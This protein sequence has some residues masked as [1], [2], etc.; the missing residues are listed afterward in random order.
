MIRSWRALVCAAVLLLPGMSQAASYTYTGIFDPTAAQYK[1]TLCFLKT[2]AD[3]DRWLCEFKS[4]DTHTVTGPL[5]VPGVKNG[6]KI[7][8]VMGCGTTLKFD[9]GAK[10]TIN[11][12][13]LVWQGCEGNPI[14][15]TPSGAANG[16]WDGVRLDFVRTFA[17]AESTDFG[18]GISQ[19]KIVGAKTALQILS[20]EDG[21]TQSPAIVLHGI[22]IDDAVNTGVW[23]S[24]SNVK[25]TSLS[26]DNVSSLGTAKGLDIVNAVVE[27]DGVTMFNVA[28]DTEASFIYATSNSSLIVKS[29]KLQWATA[30][31]SGNA[32][33]VYMYGGDLTI[34]ET[35]IQHVNAVAGKALGV[36]VSQNGPPITITLTN[37]T[38]DD[39]YSTAD[40]SI[41]GVAISGTINK[42]NVSGLTIS[43]VVQKSATV[44]PGSAAFGMQYLGSGPLNINGK[45]TI[46]TVT[47][48]DKGYATG[49]HVSCTTC[50]LLGNTVDAKIV[51]NVTAEL[52][53]ANGIDTG[54]GPAE[55]SLTNL[56]V[57]N[58]V[59]KGSD[60]YGARLDAQLLSLTDSKILNVA[61][62]TAAYGLY[63]SL[64]SEQQALLTR[65]TVDAISTTKDAPLYGI[66]VVT[67]SEVVAPSVKFVDLSV[68][69]IVQDTAGAAPSKVYGVSFGSKQIAYQIEGCLI[70]TISGATAAEAIYA[71]GSGSISKC[72]IADVGSKDQKHAFGINTEGMLTLL[73]SSF[74][75]IIGFGSN[76]AAVYVGNTTTGTVEISDNTFDGITGVAAIFLTGNFSPTIK[77]L[78]NKI[79]RWG[80]YGIFIGDKTDPRPLLRNNLVARPLFGPFVGPRYGIYIWNGDVQFNTVDCGEL[81]NHG[82]FVA[83]TVN[84]D[85]RANIAQHCTTSGIRFAT[86]DPLKHNIAF[87]NGANN[88]CNYMKSAACSAVAPTDNHADDPKLDKNWMPTINSPAYLFTEVDPASFTNPPSV[89]LF[90]TKRLGRLDIGAY[91]IPVLRTLTPEKV[92]RN[93]SGATLTVQGY[94]LLKDKISFV[95]VNDGVKIK[96]TVWDVTVDELTDVKLSVDVDKALAPDTLVSLLHWHQALSET[97]WTWKDA[98][99]IT[100]NK[101]PVFN[102]PPGTAQCVAGW[103]CELELEIDDPDN[104]DL[105]V[106]S[107]SSDFTLSEQNTTNNQTKF[108]LSFRTLGSE[109]KQGTVTITAGDGLNNATHQVALT[110]VANTPP[111]KP[112]LSEPAELNGRRESKDGKLTWLAVAD[113]TLDPKNP[114][115]Y[116]CLVS[117][118]SDFSTGVSEVNAGTALEC[119]PNVFAENQTYFVK[120]RAVDGVEPT[121]YTDS[122]VYAV[123]YNSTN[124]APPAPSAVSP[125]DQSVFGPD[126]AIALTVANVVDPEQDSVTYEFELALANDFAGGNLVKAYTAVAPGTTNTNQLLDV[127]LT[128][129]TTYFWRARAVDAHGLAGPWS[130]V[131]SFS[132]ASPP[133]SDAGDDATPGDDSVTPDAQVDGTTGTDTAPASDIDATTQPGPDSV[134]GGDTTAGAE[135]STSTNKKGGGCT[136]QSSNP[137]GTSSGLALLFVLLLGG[138][139]YRR[140]RD[141]TS[142]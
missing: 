82:I 142:V 108:T 106:T 43:N 119:T 125:V 98:L 60:A 56:T 71:R 86:A 121:K 90:G 116:K 76:S 93:S 79:Q 95:F 15:F 69:N 87:D 113:A 89:S 138:W 21:K 49:L 41:G 48:K 1:D 80:D 126:D 32:F 54:T 128:P 27:V 10:L 42:V 25:F 47:A 62:V 8:L 110:T 37:T 17:L 26:I 7:R 33:G 127:A 118:F 103:I 29:G 114:T 122:D 5:S 67:P 30:I 75:K 35:L 38:I 61:G 91:E 64:L 130:A 137:G 70:Q 14:V 140:R 68:T 65:V 102:S 112:Q 4:T 123:F 72:T 51:A 12:A 9:G 63:T 46:N 115:V 83:A 107:E 6:T 58:V 100:E 131:L 2:L 22:D 53:K 36:S 40:A 73:E 94:N 97:Q 81:V 96:N 39:V 34:G 124:D 99:T 133:Q 31:T 129:G 139:R 28:G 52:G 101:T 18:A 59:S 19:L 20:I 111:G 134:A 16:L 11:A 45:L 13:E 78:R 109:I 105:S 120:I 23:V 92:A 74:S 50:K 136:V 84:S 66:Q 24:T 57:D 104:T 3:G 141:L 117:S 77:I 44:D 88:D 85:I 135:T 55:I 132:L